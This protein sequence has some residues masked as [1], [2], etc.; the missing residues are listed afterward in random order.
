MHRSQILS[1]LRA[2]TDMTNQSKPLVAAFV[3]ALTITLLGVLLFFK[4]IAES[5]TSFVSV[6]PAIGFL[7]YLVLSIGLFSW[8]TKE[9][10]NVY[11]GAFIVAAPQFIF[12]IDLTLRG[13]R[14]LPTAA[15]GTLLLTVTWLAVA[16]AYSLFDRAESARGDDA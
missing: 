13:E 16:Y 11:K 7:I 5:D 12:I 15:A 4:P 14:G 8:A 6:H 2:V 10:G 9:M 1:V 3:T